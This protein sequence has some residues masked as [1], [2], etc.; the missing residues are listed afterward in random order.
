M[1][2]KLVLNVIGR[3]LFYFSFLFFLPIFV[4]LYY[5]E[6][7]YP[8]LKAFF[9]TFLLGLALLYLRP[10]VEFIK[11]REALAIVSLT[12]FSVALVSSIPFILV[13]FNPIDA[14]FESMSGFTTTGAT[15]V[16]NIEGL[17]KSVL[18]WRSFIQWLGGM[19]IIVLFL[20]IFPTMAKKGEILFF[21]EYPGV[22]LE[23]IKPRVKDVAIILYTIYLIY[24]F[25]EVSILHLLGVP[26]FDALLHT[27]TTLSTGG[28]STHTK[29]IAYFNN[30]A[31]E[32]VIII[33]MII[34]GTNFA[35]HYYLLREGKSPF[36]DTEFKVYISVVAIASI[37][38]IISNLSSFGLYDSI[39]VSVFQTVSILTTTGYTTTD[40][41]KW[42]DFA[43]IILLILMIIG[44]CSGSTAGGIKIIRLYI[45]LKY[46]VLQI[47]K[48][49]EPRIFRP[50]RY[51]DIILE[52]K[53]IDEIIAFT[54]LY[55]LIFIV[56]SIIIVGS[57]YDILTSISA[58]AATLGNV[59]PGMGLAGASESYSFFPVHIKLL[60][61]LNMWIGRLEIFAVLAL[62]IPHF[63]LRKW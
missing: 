48:A 15:I 41:D 4:A 39:R 43:K 1:N 59:G 36:R 44:G 13:G 24:T 47:L 8:F 31:I 17:P 25:L 10:D 56:S 12:W 55:I 50:I 35:L 26:I 58:S 63:W 54:I 45:L 14:F 19:G 22:T 37:L 30:P 32:A 28:F 5:S 60:L 33:F 62:F 49:A 46:S 61:I 23:K 57:G 21:A 42:S 27:F 9:I 29:S 11:H 38:I 51:G 53:I 52:K 20:A 7:I 16:D 40:F 6:E 18:F 34:G 3:I 2:L